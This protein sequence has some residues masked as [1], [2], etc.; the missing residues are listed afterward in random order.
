MLIEVADESLPGVGPG[1]LGRENQD[2]ALAMNIANLEVVDEVLDM[3]MLRQPYNSNPAKIISNDKLTN[4]AIDISQLS[5][6]FFDFKIVV[7]DAKNNKELTK[8]ERELNDEL[9]KLF[10]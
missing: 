9:T 8:K 7:I 1:A 5:N 4:D 2:E 3:A 10:I 6:Y